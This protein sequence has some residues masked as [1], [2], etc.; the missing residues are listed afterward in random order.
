[1]AKQKTAN[2]TD[3]ST[4]AKTRNRKAQYYLAHVSGEADP[5]VVIA[6]NFKSA[7]NAVVTITPATAADLMQAGKSGFRVVDTTDASFSPGTVESA[8]P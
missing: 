7:I 2:T 8:Q 3:A 1:M 6:R 4:P 5:V